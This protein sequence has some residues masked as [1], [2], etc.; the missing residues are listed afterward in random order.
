MTTSQTEIKLQF[1]VELSKKSFDTFCDELSSLFAVRMQCSQQAIVTET[2]EGLKKRFKEPAAL[3]S[4]EA[5]GSVDG[6]FQLV[7]D[8]NALFILA[9]LMLMHPEQMI[10]ENIKRGS[11]EKAREM[12]DVITQAVHTLLGAWNRVFRKVLVGHNRFMQTNV[13]IGNPW[14]KSEPNTGLAYDEEFVFV[15]YQIKVSSY[16]P[17]NCGIIFTKRLLSL[18]AEFETGQFVPTEEKTQ[19]QTAAVDTADSGEADAPKESDTEEKPN[20]EVAATEQNSDDAD[21]DASKNIAKEK[22]TTTVNAAEHKD[23]AAS[24]VPETIQ[25]MTQPPTTIPGKQASP[26]TSEPP[27]SDSIGEVMTLR[28]RDIMRKDVLW[29]SQDDSVQHALAKMQQHKASYI[30][31]GQDSIL[32]GIVSKSDLTAA[33]SPYLRPAF[34][35]WRRPLDD[36]TLQIKIKW[37]MSGAVHTITPQTPLPAIIENMCQLGV[38]CLPV[39]D[40]QGKV[41]GLVTVLETFKAFLKHYSGVSTASDDT[42]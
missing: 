38:R 39:V 21:V 23:S 12:S 32:T 1:I 7:F 35:K 40:P 3:Y 8:K 15:P 33:I 24:A 16:P 25:E 11:L 29:C 31:V 27:P 5:K 2:V 17:F 28:A 18:T 26:A 30:V 42:Q 19:D 37:V 41:Q 10:L 36:A 9:G 20:P 4:V 13:F 14:E 34:E 6:I 22:A